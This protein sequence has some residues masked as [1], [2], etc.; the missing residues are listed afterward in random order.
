MKAEKLIIKKNK[1]RTY[2]DMKGI[3]ID[4]SGEQWNVDQQVDLSDQM[5][6]LT[7]TTSGQVQNYA[8]S[9]LNGLGFAR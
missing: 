4:N 6:N 3:S 8:G 9:V 5:S 7:G 1:D 2:I